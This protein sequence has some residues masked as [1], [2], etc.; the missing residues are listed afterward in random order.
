MSKPVPQNVAKAYS[1]VRFSTPA[2]AKGGSLLRQTEK[3]EQYALAEL[4]PV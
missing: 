3:A 2:Q 1:Y 4:L